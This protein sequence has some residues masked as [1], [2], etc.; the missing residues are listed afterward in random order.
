LAPNEPSTLHMALGPERVYEMLPAEE[1][2]A[3]FSPRAARRLATAAAWDAKH[4]PRG[5]I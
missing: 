4:G 2:Q 1:A 3:L 5:P